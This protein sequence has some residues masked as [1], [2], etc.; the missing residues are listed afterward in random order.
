M[1]QGNPGNSLAAVA[2]VRN[3]VMLLQKALPS[4]PMGTELHTVVLKTV[5]DL[6]KNLPDI[7]GEG[8]GQISQLMQVIQQLAHQQTNRALAAA[9]QPASA[10]P[11]LPP[12]SMSP[13]GGQ[14]PGMG[15]AA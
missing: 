9:A 10:P 7:G 2:A 14:P 8:Q 5:G 6:T 3:A 11:V 1:P 12:P 13:P 4:L 15:M